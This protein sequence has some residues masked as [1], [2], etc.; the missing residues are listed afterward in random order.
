[1]QTQSRVPIVG[2]LDGYEA[3]LAEM[4]YG[5]STKLLFLKRA[6]VIIRRHED[7][8]LEYID[9]TVV[10][11][12]SQEINERYYNSELTKHYYRDLAREIQRFVS[13][14]DTG[15]GGLLPSPLRGSRQKLTPWFEQ[16]AEDF[17]S[18][19][20]HPNTSGDI[21]WVTRKYF[22]WL[23]EQGYTNLNG[24]EAT[25]IQRFLLFCSD[26]YAPSS[27]HNIKLYLKKLYAYL[28]VI[29]QSE[30]DYSALLS[31]TVSRDQKIYPTLP[32]ADIAKL[33]SSIDRTNVMGKRNYAIML[34]GTVLGLRACDVVA[35]KL[36]DIDWQR[37]EIKL[38]QSKTANPLVLP[39][40]QDVGEALQDYIL[41]A[42]PSSKSK[43]VFLR[44]KA[45]HTALTTAVTV[46]EIYENC[47]IA[48]GLPVSRRFHNLRRSLGTSMVSSG[49][50]IYDVAQVFGDASI[51]STKPYIATDIEH[52]KMCAL[53]FDAI[54]PI[55]GDTI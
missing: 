52:L 6:G 17:I 2:L 36:S 28:Y 31:F 25:H 49:V 35:L 4:G 29:G 41:N 8:G 24:V 16:I 27:I 13:Y 21:R 26:R 14:V 40:T 22:S 9:P 45:P 53:S 3:K 44:I 39:L 51:E 12:Y 32:K 18:G 34:L 1:M 42:R 43:H 11:D 10:A 48:A 47:C 30:K 55:G 54:T 33:L 37:G 5:Y 23:E 19:D 7:Q 38:L 15:A 46:G 20:F 50:S